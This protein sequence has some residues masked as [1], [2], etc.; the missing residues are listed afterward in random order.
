[1]WYGLGGRQHAGGGSSTK[2]LEMKERALMRYNKRYKQLQAVSDK[3][4]CKQGAESLTSNYEVDCGK[5]V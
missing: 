3:I 1:M 2:V 5:T 4:I